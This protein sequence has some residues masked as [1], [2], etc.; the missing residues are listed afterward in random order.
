M[1]RRLVLLGSE[2]N[3]RR[4]YE[5]GRYDATR[6]NMSALE[7]FGFGFFLFEV[8]SSLGGFFCLEVERLKL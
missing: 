1:C 2:E 8:L 4:R 6:M 7:C 5:R 3:H